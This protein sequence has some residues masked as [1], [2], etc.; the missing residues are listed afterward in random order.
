MGLNNN[1]WKKIFEFLFRIS[2]KLADLLI[3][4]MKRILRVNS[5]SKPVE[6][7]R[8]ELSRERGVEPKI[9]FEYLK[10][11][12][13]TSF[14]IEEDNIK[15]NIS[16]QD[17]IIFEDSAYKAPDINFLSKPEVTKD[18]LINQDELDINAAKLKNVLTDFKI[19]G[20]IIRVS[21]GPIVTMYELQPAPGVKASKII[22][23]SDDIARNMS[24]MSARV[25]ITPGKNV[26]GIEI[27]NTLKNPVYL[28]ELFKNEQFVN[29]ERNLILALGKDISGNAMFANLENMPHLLI[30]GT[31]GSGNGGHKCYDYLNIIQ[32]STRGL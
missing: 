10:N 9:D 21:P 27:P 14:Q 23:L 6:T 19:E 4:I 25:A 13:V 17:E 2:T 29:N 11:K 3:I 32:A 7:V 12:P 28:S 26:I 24:A 31:T 30:A 18:N 16:H 5:Y 1:E 15:T 8:D 22:S 20:E